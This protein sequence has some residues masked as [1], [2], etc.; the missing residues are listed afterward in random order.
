MSY[1]IIEAHGGPEYA[2]ICTDTDGN[3]LIFDTI[4]EAEAEA[5]NCQDGHIVEI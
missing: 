2:I 3:N 4:E 5:A 1:I